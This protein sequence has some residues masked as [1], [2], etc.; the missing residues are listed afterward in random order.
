MSLEFPLFMILICSILV[1][2]LL[3]NGSTPKL[4]RA[5]YI[6][7]VLT[8]LKASSIFKKAA[9]IYSLRSKDISILLTTSSVDRSF[10]KECR[11]EFMFF[12]VLHLFS[13]MHVDESFECFNHFVTTVVEGYASTVDLY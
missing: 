12:W 10:R 5:C 4:Y 11:L 6:P 2:Q 8:Y 9:K 1:I 3:R 7:K 13:N